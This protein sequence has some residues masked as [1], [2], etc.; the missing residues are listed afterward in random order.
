LQ[1]SSVLLNFQKKE[2]T[3]VNDFVKLATMAINTTLLIGASAAAAENANPMWK[4]GLAWTCVTQQRISCERDAACVQSPQTRNILIDYEK[5]LVILDNEPSTIGRHYAQIVDGNP[6]G[7]VVTVETDKRFVFTL[8]AVDPS[9]S[10]SKD[11]IGL[12]TRPQGGVVIIESW[13]VACNPKAP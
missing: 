1:I 11:W 3:A 7:A 2:V 8:N 12:M 4:S 10:F 13:L 5:S 6:L 9:S